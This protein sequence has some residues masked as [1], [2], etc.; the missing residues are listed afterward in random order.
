MTPTPNPRIAALEKLLD[1]PRDGAL[2]RFSLGNELLKDDNPAAAITHFRAATNWHKKE[3]V[4]RPR[5]MRDGDLPDS[6]QFVFVKTRDRGVYLERHA[7]FGG[8][9]HRAR[10]ILKRPR[11]AAECIMR[12]GI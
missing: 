2:L 12:S 10:H 9:D 7:D 5:T 1:G 8:D 4:K 11:Y 6:G 3:K